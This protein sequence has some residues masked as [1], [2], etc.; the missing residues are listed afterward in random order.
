MI[1]VLRLDGM[2]AVHAARAAFAALAG[3]DGIRWADVKLG[4]AEL[5]HDGPLDLDAVRAALA[6]VGVQLVDATSERR[7]L[8]V[9]AADDED[10]TEP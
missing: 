5:E 6:T 1:T 8:D 3:V 9:R 4:R 10:A 2:L 7:R